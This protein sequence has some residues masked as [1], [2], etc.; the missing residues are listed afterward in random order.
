MTFYSTSKEKK[1]L[2][3]F[4]YMSLDGGKTSYTEITERNNIYNLIY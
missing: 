4:S 3:Y 2:C 1:N